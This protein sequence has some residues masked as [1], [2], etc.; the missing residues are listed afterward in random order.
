[1]VVV[2]KRLLGFGGHEGFQ[3]LE[4]WVDGIIPGKYA[5]FPKKLPQQHCRIEH[6]WHEGCMKLF[7]PRTLGS[8]W[9]PMV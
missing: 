8:S 2:S 5:A 7:M 3:I 6:M 1:M 4:G 9:M